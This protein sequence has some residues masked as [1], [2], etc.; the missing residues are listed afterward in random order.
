MSTLYEIHHAYQ[1][2]STSVDYLLVGMSPRLERAT[3]RV[4][5]WGWSPL[6]GEHPGPIASAP[7]W[8]HRREVRHLARTLRPATDC[9]AARAALAVAE[10]ALSE[11]RV[12]HRR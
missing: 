12:D 3:V 6:T 8:V 11:G 4:P 10:R 7:S 5:A 2:G 1:S 9:P